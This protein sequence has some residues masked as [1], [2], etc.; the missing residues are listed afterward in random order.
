LEQLYHPQR[1]R[2][3][4]KRSGVRGAGQWRKL[5][6]DEA[7]DHI[8][9]ALQKT[10]D[11]YGPEGVAFVQGTAKGLIDSYHERFANVFGSPNFATS[12]HVCFL[13]RLLAAKLTCGFYPVPDYQ[14]SPACIMVWGANL[15]HTR[16]GEHFHSVEQFKKGARLILIDPLAIELADRADLWLRPKPGSDLALA[17][18]LL[19]VIIYENL[20]DHEF[21]DRWTMGFEQLKTHVQ[22]YAPEKVEALSW[23][24][25]EQIKQAARIYAALKPACLL[26][27]NAIDHG[28]NSFQTARA[29]T[30]LRAVTGNLDQ[31]G[32]DLEPIYPLP[33]AASIK[34]TL[35][36]Q[37]PLALWAKRVGARDRLIP[38]FQRVL[39]QSLVKAVLEN[40]PYPL[41]AM[42]VH[43][44]NPLLTFGNAGRV[45]QALQNL[46]FLLVTDRFMTPTAALADIV[47]PAATYLEYD[48]IVAPPYY[49]VAQIQQKAVE[50][51]ACRSDFEIVNGIARRLGLGRFFFENLDDFF[52]LV[53]EPSGLT[54]QEFREQGVLTGA[55]QDH[56]Y[57]SKGFA[58]PSGKVE[59]YSSQLMKWGFDSLPAYREVPGTCADDP[60]TGDRKY[61][62][63]LTTRKSRFYRHS[64]SR[65]IQSLRAKH[66]DPLVLV[67]PDTAQKLAIRDGDWVRIETRQGRIKQKARLSEKIDPRI[68]AVD[69]GWW[70]PEKGPENLFGWSEA[71]LNMLTDD[72]PPFNQEMGSSQFRGIPCRISKAEE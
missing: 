25:A 21:V 54:F 4:L 28:I 46:D 1:L 33:G 44:S 35:R 34:V 63:V 37:L 42:Y 5:S 40:D 72:T 31:A 24:P 7:F 55:R 61:P 45:L 70:F 56:K 8:A 10:K 41:R 20:Y 2:H 30:I 64:D 65:Q 38:L 69:F 50:I 14:G 6:W 51:E 3:P 43:A 66:P 12:G 19:H 59:L 48:N 71:N 53:L 22:A 39:P 16:H 23:V 58:T 27:G 29:L 67:H 26:W 11:R 18:G 57:L 32:G 15:A 36:E 13:P 62:L 68:V 47:L 17:L 49:P 60:A 52:D 9:A